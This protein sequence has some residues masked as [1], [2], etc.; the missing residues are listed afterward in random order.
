MTAD[1]RRLLGLV[2]P[3]GVSLGFLVPL[4]AGRPS[5]AP[6]VQRIL[7]DGTIK[8]FEPYEVPD[9]PTVDISARQVSPGSPAV[10]AFAFGK[11]DIVIV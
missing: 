10:H 3:S 2:D 5:N 6:L 1:I 11:D 4:F 7:P 9:A 8:R